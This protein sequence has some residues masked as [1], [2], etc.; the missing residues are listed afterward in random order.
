MK[1]TISPILTEADYDAALEEIAG[2]M[3]AK[4]GTRE[5]A[6]LDVLATLVEA[7]EEKHW[8]ID[9]PNPIDAIRA[10][11]EETGLRQNAKP[12]FADG[13]DSHQSTSGSGP[14]N[15]T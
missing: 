11:M 6:K 4:P 14:S 13:T 3:E 15:V 10:R 7:Y 5:G 2:L 9:L 12:V 8:P 1:I